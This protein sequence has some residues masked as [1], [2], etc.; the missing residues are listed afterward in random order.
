MPVLQLFN[1][2]PQEIN[3]FCI[4][5][6]VEYVAAF[7]TP[8]FQVNSLVKANS[9]AGIRAKVKIADI[10]L[11]FPEPLGV[12]RQLVPVGFVKQFLDPFLVES[13]VAYV[14]SLLPVLFP[15][16]AYQVEI[17]EPVKNIANLMNVPVN[18]FSYLEGFSIYL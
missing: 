15:V 10:C 9:D 14:P 12:S 7:R 8:V 11:L 5:L 13:P 6:V 4:I 1:L 2:C 17:V 16:V 18:L 3:G